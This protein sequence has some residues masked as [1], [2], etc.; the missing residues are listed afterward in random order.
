MATYT[1][2][3]RALDHW[4]LEQ[5][6]ASFLMCVLGTELVFSAGAAEALNCWVISPAPFFFFNK[7]GSCS[8]LRL[9]GN[10]L[11]SQRMISNWC[12]CFTSPVLGWQ[13]S[14]TTLILMLRLGQ[15]TVLHACSSE[16]YQLSYISS[17]A[18]KLLILYFCLLSA[19]IIG[20]TTMAR[21]MDFL[22]L[23]VWVHLRLV[24]WP[25]LAWYSLRNPVTFDN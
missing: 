22:S 14:G 5:L 19:R 16:L 17:H 23:L 9:D 3:S 1:D 12:S 2:Q 18:H 6:G 15:N 7:G 24:M 11:C 20:V 10:L 21:K 25:W 13:A 4:E 8:R